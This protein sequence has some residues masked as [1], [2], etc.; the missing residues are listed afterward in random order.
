[1][2]QKLIT[3]TLLAIGGGA[4]VA[5]NNGATTPLAPQNQNLT[6][7][8]SGQTGSTCDGI[9]QWDSNATY[10]TAGTA[11]VRDGKEYKNN[12]W[13][14][15]NDPLTDS[16]AE[17]SGKPWT[18]ITDCGVAP[19]PTP[20][21]TASPVSPTP[22]PENES[23]T[24]LPTIKFN[25]K[26][27][28]SGDLYFH[29]NL[30][31]GAGNIEKIQLTNNFTDLIISN[32]VAGAVLGHMMQEK[33]PALHFNRDYI[34][35]TAFAQL[36]QEN[37]NTATYVNSSDYINTQAERRTLLAAGQG[38]PYQLND[39]SKRLEN[40]QGL[41]LI[42]Y[43][44][45]QK[46]LGFSVEAQDNNSQT[47]KTGP[48][49]LDQKYFGPLAA[50]YFH[51]NDINRLAQNNAETWGPQYQ[52]YA[53][54]MSNLAN[55][56]AGNDD[57]YNMYDLILNAAYNAGTYST[58]IGDYY[59][60]CAGMYGSG[61][62]ATQV[63][64]VGDYSLSDSQ[65]QQKIAT[66]EAIGSTF[67]LYPRQIRIYLDQIYNKQTFQSDAFKGNVKIS[68]SV[69][70]VRYVFA[71]MMQTVAYQHDGKYDYITEVQANQ[72]FDRGL[73]Q[74]GITTNTSLSLNNTAQREMFFNLL[75]QVIN[76]VATE[77]NFDF[78]AV[79]QS[80]IGA[81]VKPTPD[82]STSPTP[83][84]DNKCPVSALV[85]PQGRGGYASGTIVVA[86]DRQYY[87]CNS[88]VA[89]WCNSPAEWAYAPGSG[90]A[91]DGAWSKLNCN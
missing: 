61:S 18:L 4:L 87:E 26:S 44:A 46:G 33:Y 3:T 17:G 72:A 56:K 55:S 53:K 79:T 27:T 16:G 68:I 73:Q 47:S 32:Y 77:L 57:V 12:W 43:V 83:T 19:T 24:L 22:A 90:T 89:A 50:V 49:S 63:Q 80:T 70:D 29:L 45:I 6:F 10:A 58:I 13:T 88:G 75:D 21:P 62:E 8:T 7:S 20:T 74:L 37:I 85:Y 23:T 84:P 76:N 14:K 28:A 51:F 34:Y 25:G 11:V 65:Y 81:N 54:C 40:Q 5:C 67:I 64:Y 31:M 82:P 42:N 39:Y 52:Y 69:M 9:K 38:G 86:S 1:M 59:R 78:S 71:N 2:K 41:G 36:L 48:L 60:I 30:P 15:G 35:G 66:K 91:S